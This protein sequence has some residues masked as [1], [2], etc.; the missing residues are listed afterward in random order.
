MA[1]D[2]ASQL[3]CLQGWLEA[4]REA[5]RER[6]RAARKSLYFTLAIL[7]TRAGHLLLPT[8]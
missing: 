2:F 7:L 1:M 6:W 5:K 3:A 4:L 8:L